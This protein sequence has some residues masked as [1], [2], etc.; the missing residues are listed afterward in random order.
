MTWDADADVERLEAAL[1]AY[2]KPAATA[3]CDELLSKVYSTEEPYP[4]NRAPR[5]LALLRRK[6]YF[7]QMELLAD[8]FIQTGAGSPKVRRLYAQALLDQGR[9]TAAQLVLQQLVQDTDKDDAGENAE[10]RGLLGRAWKQMYVNAKEPS[11]IRNQKWLD[12]AAL[13][14][15]EPYKRE[16]KSYG[17]HGIN[18]VAV[19]DRGVRD[20]VP[21]K[22]PGLPLPATLAADILAVIEDK[23]SGV[24][25]SSGIWGPPSRRTSRSTTRRRH[26][27]GPSGTWP[28]PRWTP[29]S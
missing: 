29:S 16:P 28:T 8:A 23:F 9:F 11:V 12:A 10:A 13:A 3:L 27:D 4:P 19:V 6:R 1:R 14:Y 26:S 7:A 22:T 5:L 18:V 17:W 15:Y 20:N 25:L 24:Q 21:L 2:D